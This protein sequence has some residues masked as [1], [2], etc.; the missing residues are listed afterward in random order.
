MYEDAQEIFD[1]L[2]IDTGGESPYIIH[3]W[4]AFEALMEKEDPIRS[5]GI[6]PF[7]L[8]FMFTI[9][10]KV[11]RLSAYKKTEYLET[12]NRCRLYDN[13][14]RPTLKNNPPIPNDAGVIASYCSVRNLS[15]LIEGQL[16]DF[17]KIIDVDAGIIKK[18]KELINIR[19]NYAHAN[20]KIAE[21]IELLIDEYLSVLKGIQ[22]KFSPI[23][24]TVASEWL[25]EVDGEEEL[26]E[27]VKARLL[28]NYICPADFR[29][30]MLAIFSLD[31]DTP[32]E[33]WQAAVSKVL[34]SRSRSGLLWLQHI[35]MNHPDSGRRFNVI[36]ILGKNGKLDNEFRDSL[37]ANEKDPEVI[38]LLK[39]V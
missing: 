25:Q 11:Y 15:L 6:L 1:Y 16:F 26:E 21:D 32:F 23:S 34:E 4:G 28:K 13:G 7:H 33:E 27:F 20:G 8:L 24:D 22:D 10:Y 31:E 36:Q 37:L 5:F 35:A 3:L 18:A 39:N 9:Q 14:N 29:S 38:E 19:N 12:L 2:P 17:L 30:G